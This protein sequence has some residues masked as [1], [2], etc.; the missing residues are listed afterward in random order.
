LIVLRDDAFEPELAGVAEH[1]LAVALDVVIEPNA[2]ASSNQDGGQ[3]RLADVE[4]VAA[5]IVAVQL[6][7]VEG[8]QEHAGVVSA[9]TDALEARHS[10]LVAGDGLAIDDAGPRAQPSQSLHDQREAVC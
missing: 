6:N 5:V 10:A 8:I 2:M 4:R 9:V 7:Q 1:G 3:R